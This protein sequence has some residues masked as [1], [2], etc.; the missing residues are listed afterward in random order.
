[1]ARRNNKNLDKQISADYVSKKS[2]D[3]LRDAKEWLGS[4][5]ELR[6]VQKLYKTLSLIHIS[7]PT[8]PY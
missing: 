7:E 5:L 3:E 1:M 4:L 2:T 8:R 6:K